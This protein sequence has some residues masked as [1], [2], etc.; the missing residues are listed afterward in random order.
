MTQQQAIIQTVSGRYIDLYNPK[1]ED[2]CLEDIAHHLSHV[3]RFGGATWDFYS[4]AEHSMAVA[5]L[6]PARLSLAGL[7]HDASEAFLGDMVS[8]VKRTLPSY[9]YIEGVV[10]SAIYKQF[11]I[12]LSI[13]DAALVKHADLVVLA[14]ERAHLMPNDGIDWPMLQGIVPLDLDMHKP[15]LPHLAKQQFIRDAR[16]YMT[17]QEALR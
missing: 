1:P 5:F 8:T 7:L 4:V 13:E 10:Q 17:Q 11:D 12:D 6:L 9:Q 3:C 2:F 16:D 15:M 14:T